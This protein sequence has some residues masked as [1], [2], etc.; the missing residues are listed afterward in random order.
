MHAT[1]PLLERLYDIAPTDLLP[2][3]LEGLYD[4][5]LSIA[6]PRCY[7]NFVSSVDG[8]VALESRRNSGSIISGKNQA[9]RFVMGLLRAFA[10]A[11]LVGAGTVRAEGRGAQWTPAFICP[12]AAADFA[13]LRTQLGTP[14]VPRL[15]ILTA[16]GEIDPAQPAIQAGPI[17]LAPDRIGETL[18][19]RMPPSCEV[20][21]FAADDRIDLRDAVEELNQRGYRR[22]LA[23]GGPTAFGDLLRHGL[24]DELFL[25]VA[26]VLLG[27]DERSNR[28]GLI[29]NALLPAANPARL[30][31][32]SL[33]RS[34]S[35][36]FLRYWLR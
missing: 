2:G 8:V 15:V 4:G 6:A 13:A 26:P 23:E 31:L 28:L 20:V 32:A 1:T 21:T 11:V 30:E 24:V 22:L 35:Y 5:G 18:R 14:A 34:G 7:A 29:E 25:T 10:D 36:L 33:R 12:S 3:A 17:I 9:D 16:S 19:R 27:R